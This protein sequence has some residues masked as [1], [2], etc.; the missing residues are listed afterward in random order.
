MKCTHATLVLVAQRS[1]WVCYEDGGVSWED[2]LLAGTDL[3]WMDRLCCGWIVFV[4]GS[5]RWF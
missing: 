3:L 2:L 1:D 4:C 5:G